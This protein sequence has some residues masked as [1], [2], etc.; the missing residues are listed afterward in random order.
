[1]KKNEKAMKGT[2]GKA[3]EDNNM[4]KET[5]EGKEKGNGG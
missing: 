4:R 1:M 5:I 3:R 2:K